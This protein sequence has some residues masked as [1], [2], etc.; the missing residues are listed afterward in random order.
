ACATC[1]NPVD[2]LRADRVRILQERFRYFCSAACASGF[3]IAGL[4]PIPQPRRRRPSDSPFVIKT[5]LGSNERL[6][7]RRQIAVELN[8]VIHEDTLEPA[9]FRDSSS[10][11]EPHVERA[12]EATPP[13]EAADIGSLLLTLAMLGGALGIALILAGDSPAALASRLVVVCV[14]CASLVAQCLMGDRDEREPHPLSVLAAPVAATLT[15]VAGTLLE[16]PLVQ[17]AITLS[18]VIVGMLALSLWLVRR[19]RRPIDAERAQIAALLEHKSQR[20]IGEEIAPV[21]A[22]D[23]RPGEEI[24]VDDG[25]IV[26]IDG[27]ISAGGATLRPWLT[28][29]GSV[30]CAE[31]DVV[32]AGARVLTGRIRVVVG[33]AGYDRTWVRLTNDP[34]RRADLLAPLPRAGRLIAERAAPLAAGLAGL[35]SFAA[36]AEPMTIALFA[37]AAQAA[38]AHPAIAQIAALAVARGVLDGLRRGVA[39]RTA[40]AL[41]TAGRVS[42]A[43]F[44]ARGTLLLG[45]PEVANVEPIGEH[46]A[47]TVLALIAGAESGASDPVATAMLRAARARGVRPDGARSHNAQPGLGITAVSSSGQRLVVGS[48]ALM[49]QERVSVASAEGKINELEGLGRSVL[50]VALGGRLVGVVGLQDGLRPGARAAVQYLADV[51]VEPVLLSGDARETCEAL[52]RTLDIEHV[53]PEILPPDRGEEIRKLAAGGGSVAVIGRSPVDDGALGAA[54]VSVALSSAGSTTAEWSVQL[55]SDDIK[56]AAFAIRLA[57]DTRREARSGLVTALTPAVA[58]ALAVTFSLVP[59]LIAPLAATVAGCLALY[60]ARGQASE[61]H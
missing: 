39:F 55:A 14:A 54:D 15:A 16:E 21:R 4:T 3:D 7:A 8:S 12:D 57:H 50:L 58:G 43:I 28:A 44:C 53:R 31:G 26:P 45:E 42:M 1:G 10:S 30:E 2:P 9:G 24:V 59:P 40:D 51:G 18:A 6:E 33:W 47:S 37:L 48:R 22:R 34:R 23:L 32:V 11:T 41:D 49:L 19:A 35:T 60:R 36:N 52:G 20:I 27:T 25:E 61:R 38:V 56:E 17:S 5:A 13:S 29:A 46:D